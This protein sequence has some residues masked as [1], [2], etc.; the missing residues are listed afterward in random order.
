MTIK[1]L[2]E[3]YLE[4]VSKEDQ[5]ILNYEDAIRKLKKEFKNP[6]EYINRR[7]FIARDITTSQTRRQCYVQAIVDIESLND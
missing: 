5:I 6:T 4:K 7:T 1:K 2:I 3:E